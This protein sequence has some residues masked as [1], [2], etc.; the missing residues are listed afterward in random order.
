MVAE[1]RTRGVA[2]VEMVCPMHHLSCM[3]TSSIRRQLLRH[4]RDLLARYHDECM[5]AEEELATR[6]PEDVERAT[7]EWDARVLAKLGDTDLQALAAVVA[8]IRRIDDGTYGRCD[9]CGDR[10]AS[11]RLEALP[12]ATKC[13]GCATTAA[14]HAR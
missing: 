9:T 13:I 14:V 10:I 5:R 2:A 12:T 6:D 1:R 3:R 8:A 11:A 7:E 4:R